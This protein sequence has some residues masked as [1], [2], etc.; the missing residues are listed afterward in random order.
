[1]FAVDGPCVLWRMCCENT[2]CGCRP[3]KVCAAPRMDSKRTASLSM[4]SNVH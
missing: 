3:V 4:H 2:L 1:M